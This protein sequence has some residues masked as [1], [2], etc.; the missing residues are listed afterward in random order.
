TKSGTEQTFLKLWDIATSAPISTASI[1]LRYPYSAQFAADGHMLF[2][3]G[4]RQFVVWDAQKQQQ[5]T[6]IAGS[7]PSATP[8][9]KSIVYVS[10]GNVQLWSPDKATRSIPAFGPAPLLMSFSPDSKVLM[11]AGD[12]KTIQLWDTQSNQLIKQI[13]ED[14]FIN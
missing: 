11:S 1:D 5:I 14:G 4:L 9:L 2:V 6:S 13:T 7:S 10:D 12:G 8:D 3:A